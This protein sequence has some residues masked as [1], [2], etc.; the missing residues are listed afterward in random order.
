MQNLIPV[1]IDRD[2]SK[3]VKISSNLCEEERWHLTS[4]LQANVDVFAWSAFDMSGINPEVIVHQLNVDIKHRLDK[5]KKHSFALEQQKAIQEEVNKLP[6]AGF[7]QEVYYLEWLANVMLVK[8][9]N[10]SWPY[11]RTRGGRTVVQTRRY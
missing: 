7:V 5:Q 6:Q 2:P 3:V 4:F 1:P 8:K 11:H 9:M 10:K